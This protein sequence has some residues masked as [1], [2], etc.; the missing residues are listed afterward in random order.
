MILGLIP[1]PHFDGRPSPGNKGCRRSHSVIRGVLE[2]PAVRTHLDVCVYSYVKPRLENRAYSAL[3]L[4]KWKHVSYYSWSEISAQHVSVHI[5]E[6]LSHKSNCEA[7]FRVSFFLR[8]KV[9]VFFSLC[10][11]WPAG[12]WLIRAT[13]FE[14]A[15]VHWLLL[16]H[17]NCSPSN[18]GTLAFVGEP[19]PNF[20]SKLWYK[21][22]HF[23]AVWIYGLCL[24]VLLYVSPI[25]H[26]FRKVRPFPV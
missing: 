9:V 26:Q 17:E 19:P 24:L 13:L 7:N 21:F 10:L 22:F 16:V 20:S 12:L 15:R 8:V 14:T 25:H 23:G 6:V 3:R 5:N 1:Q 4:T 18:G 11:A 2:A